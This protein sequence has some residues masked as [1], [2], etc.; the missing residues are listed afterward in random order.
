MSSSGDT[1]ERVVGDLDERLVVDVDL[2]GSELA[3]DERAH[4]PWPISS[5]TASDARSAAATGSSPRARPS[6]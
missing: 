4:Q 3:G 2:G 5:A 1:G 6:R